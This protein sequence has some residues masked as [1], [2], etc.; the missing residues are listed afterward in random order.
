[1]TARFLMKPGDLRKFYDD[2]F[3]VNVG[4]NGHVFL[5]LDLVGNEVKILINEKVIEGFTAFSI[6]MRSRRLDGLS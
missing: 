1:M 3:S 6:E 4:F 5:V 2:G